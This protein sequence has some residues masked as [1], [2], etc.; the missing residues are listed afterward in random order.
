MVWH[1]IDHFT[2]HG[3]NNSHISISYE[4]VMPNIQASEFKAKCIALMDQFAGSGETINITKNCKLVAKLK[5]YRPPRAPSLLGRTKGD[6]R[7][8]ITLGVPLAEWRQSLIVSGLT[9]LPLNGTIALRS[10]DFNAL[11]GDPAD[12]FIAAT[13]LVHDATLITADEKLL[14]WRH[15]LARQDA[16]L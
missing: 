13:A 4:T 16:R 2:A 9:E 5:P 12:R 1:N 8:R 6:I 11:H 15:P 7:V 14:K 3:H 10:L